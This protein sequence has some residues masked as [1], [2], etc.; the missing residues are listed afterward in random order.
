M[1]L[2]NASCS[3][4]DQEP[5]FHL[6]KHSKEYPAYNEIYFLR[7]ENFRD[8]SYNNKQALIKTE[9]AV[10]IIYLLDNNDQL[11]TKISRHYVNSFDT[12]SANRVIKNYNGNKED[13]LKAINDSTFTATVS[14]QKCRI[15]I[16]FIKQAENAFLQTRFSLKNRV[17][18]N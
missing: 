13:I 4:S 11:N 12:I 18:K 8:T 10:E 15:D 9:D 3:N 2:I 1:L 5:I 7:K 17:I 6:F 14:F 16:Q